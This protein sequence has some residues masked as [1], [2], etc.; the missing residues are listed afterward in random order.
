MTTQC[1]ALAYR[2]TFST[3]LIKITPTPAGVQI[4]VFHSPSFTGEKSYYILSVGCAHGYKY[5]IPRGCLAT[6][7]LNISQA[8][9]SSQIICI[10]NIISLTK[11]YIVRRKLPIQ[12]LGVCEG[13]ETRTSAYRH[14]PSPRA[15]R[16]TIVLPVVKK[17]RAR[18]RHTPHYKTTPTH[19]PVADPAF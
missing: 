13:V 18:E 6:C 3:H 11:Q 9:E 5:C 14:F 19:P 10:K 4:T 15:P 16:D 12:G 17:Q 7:L 2:H 8:I 1:I